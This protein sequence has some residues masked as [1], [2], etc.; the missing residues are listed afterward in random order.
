MAEVYLTE[1]RTS[2][3]GGLT[4]RWQ[5]TFN[6]VD[7]YLGALTRYGH[8]TGHRGIE[9]ADDKLSIRRR[10]LELGAE[11]PEANRV[12]VTIEFGPSDGQEAILE[13]LR[14]DYGLTPVNIPV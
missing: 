10:L 2:N 11:L 1:T 9:F 4:E 3:L 5:K 13:G 8:F 14:E 6:G 12:I 7:G